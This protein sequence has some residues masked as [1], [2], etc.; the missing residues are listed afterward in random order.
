MIKMITIDWITSIEPRVGIVLD[1]ARHS[2]CRT[3]RTYEHLKGQFDGLVGYTAYHV[4]L[5]SSEAYETVM[6]ALNAA[7]HQNAG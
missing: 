3:W 1:K 2:R 7:L 5:R 4:E 6:R